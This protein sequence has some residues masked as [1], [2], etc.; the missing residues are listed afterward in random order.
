MSVVAGAL[1]LAGFTAALRAGANGQFS[2]RQHERLFA[3]PLTLARA[4]AWILQQSLWTLNRRDCWAAAQ[5]LAPIDVKRLVWDH[6]RDELE[7]NAERGVEDHQ[8]L[9]IRQAALLGLSPDD[10][11]NVEMHDGTR[12]CTYA[13]LHVVRTSDWRKSIAACAALEISNSS[14]WVDGGGMSLRRGMSFERQLGIPFEKQVSHREHAEVDV[15]H[16]NILMTVARR[17]GTTQQDLDLMLAGVRESWQIER[18]WKGCVADMM[19]AI[20]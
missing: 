5:S 15:E 2:C 9:A 12:T 16:A 20:D 11:E 3:V 10:F 18:S 14:E 1:D 7:G 8:N 4:R 17:P 6:E 19:E 13:W